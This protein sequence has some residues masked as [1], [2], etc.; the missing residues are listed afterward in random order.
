MAGEVASGSRVEPG[1]TQSLGTPVSAPRPDTTL[2]VV[3]GEDLVSVARNKLKISLVLASAP[4]ALAAALLLLRWA[5]GLLR[6]DESKAAVVLLL[7]AP[8]L[9]AASVSLRRTSSWH[10]MITTFE[11]SLISALVDDRRSRLRLLIAGSALAVSVSCFAL[12]ATGTTRYL[13]NWYVF[14]ALFA[15][16]AFLAT[17]GLPWISRSARSLGHRTVALVTSAL[18]AT[19]SV[20]NCLRNREVE[21]S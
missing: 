7:L 1:M 15:W 17:A 12:G 6:P 5:T 2:A 4:L 14:G 18:V 21:A 10:R 3:A 19:V 20:I 13:F 8:A 9:L 11:M 16:W